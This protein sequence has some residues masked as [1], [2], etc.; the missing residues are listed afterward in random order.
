MSPWEEA[1]LPLGLWGLPG[2]ERAD[3]G[4]CDGPSP[5][6]PDRLGVRVVRLPEGAVGRQLERLEAQTVRRS[7]NAALLTS[8]LR[9]IEGIDPFEDDPRVTTHAHHLY[10]FRYGADSSGLSRDRFVEALCAEGI[11]CA[12][13]YR[14]LYGEE[15]FTARFADYPLKSAYFGGKP[16]YSRISCPVTER[17]CAS[18]AVWL[19][20]N[21]LL[22]PAEDMRDIAAAIGKVVAGAHTLI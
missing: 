5:G 3:L 13:G 4:R 6:S 7:E 12:S 1:T 10:I 9:D 18:E 22:G 21:M 17:V 16:D 15:A 8:L 19:T 14:P 11:P 20:Q 2:D